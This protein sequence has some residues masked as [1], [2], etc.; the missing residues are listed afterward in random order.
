MPQ[1]PT[2]E[3][4]TSVCARPARFFCLRPRE[5]PQSNLKKPETDW[6]SA[7]CPQRAHSGEEFQKEVKASHYVTTGSCLP[8]P[9][10]MET[11]RRWMLIGHC[12]NLLPNVLKVLVANWF[13]LLFDEDNIVTIWIFR[14]RRLISNIQFKFTQFS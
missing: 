1:R 5:T 7:V 13:D 12:H 8:V 11:T 4:L 14:V 10:V 2:D 3:K 9:R 6:I